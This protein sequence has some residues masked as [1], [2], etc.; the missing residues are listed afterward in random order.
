MDYSVAIGDIFGSLTIVEKPQRRIGDNRVIV[1]CKCK[2]GG[3]IAPRMQHLVIGRV[4]SCGCLRKQAATINGLN[5]KRHGKSHGT[6]WKSYYSMRDRCCNPK[7]QSFADYGGRGIK[8]CDRW[9]QG[10]DNFFIDMGEKP[11]G[12][13]LERIDTEGDYSPD[14]CRWATRKEQANNRRNNNRIEAFGKSLTI[15]E[16]SDATGLDPMTIRGRLKRGLAAEAALSMPVT[17]RHLRRGGNPR[18]SAYRSCYSIV[19]YVDAM[20]ENGC[21]WP[22]AASQL[23]ENNGLRSCAGPGGNP[24]Q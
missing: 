5:N 8:V 2:C 9:L 1:R 13:T 6:E 12:Q 21:F 3:E 19:V 14:N 20:A 24:P 15:A 11:T 4:K 10:F 18:A 16:W 7:H 17:P 22:L 23:L